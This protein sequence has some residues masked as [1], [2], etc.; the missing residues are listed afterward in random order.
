MASMSTRLRRCGASR[1]ISAR[2][3]AGAGSSP[4]WRWAGA[5]GHPQFMPTVWFRLAV[6]FDG[7]GKRDIIG[8]MPDYL[9]S[10][11]NYL[12]KAGWGPGQAWGFEVKLPSSFNE[13][14]AGR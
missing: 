7:D 9:A 3:P 11:A 12:K 6:D 10:M 1:P 13:A 2:R 5:F 4:R 8:S 14:L